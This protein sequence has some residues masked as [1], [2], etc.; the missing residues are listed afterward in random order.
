MSDPTEIFLQPECCAIPGEGRLW[1]EHDAP[2]SCMDGVPWTRYVRADEIEY[3]KRTLADCTDACNVWRREISA[4]K[5]ELAEAR[6]LLR[7]AATILTWAADPLSDIYLC[8][9][10][11]CLACRID[12][13]LKK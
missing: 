3:L 11:D 5:R 12:A 10:Q 4:L 8:E 13:F 1:C 7:E 6:K 9:K 2:E